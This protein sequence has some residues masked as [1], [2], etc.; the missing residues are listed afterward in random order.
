M[1]ETGESTESQGQ[2]EESSQAARAVPATDEGERALGPEDIDLVIAWVAP[3]GVEIQTYSDYL[4]ETLSRPEFGFDVS[5]IKLID[6]IKERAD[7]LGGRFLHIDSQNY[8]RSTR[9][10]QAA[11]DWL[12]E[13]TDPGILAVV[14]MSDIKAYREDN[15]QSSRRAFIVRSLKHTQE[16]VELRAVYGDA[17]FLIGAHSSYE[18]RLAFLQRKCGGSVDRANKLMEID[19]S[20]GLDHGQQTRDLFELCDAYVRHSAAL[21]S[22]DTKTEID[23]IV[24]LIFGAISV[25]PRADEY[26]MSIAFRSAEQSGDL[27]RQVGSAVFSKGGDLISTGRNDVPKAGGGVYRVRE[28]PD[29]SDAALRYDPGQK[30]RDDLI[31]D[32]VGQVA[33]SDL[34]RKCG[35]DKQRAELTAVVKATRLKHL[36]EF[37]RSVHAEMDALTS[38]ARRGVSTQDATLYVTTFPCHTCARHIIASGIGRVVYLEPYPKSRALELHGD[39]ICCPAL[40]P[41]GLPLL[42][43]E[44]VTSVDSRE[45]VQFEPLVGISPR[46]YSDFFSLKTREGKAIE[47]KAPDGTLIGRI[48]AEMA[49]RQLRF[50]PRNEGLIERELNAI[51]RLSSTA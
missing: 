8:Y 20:E 17:F 2:A 37:G 45:K 24:E 38:C 43:G 1:E 7:L 9:A 16:A 13:V 10:K 15:K 27:A 36:I 19:A 4:T 34:G 25:S 51:R 14:A 22:K 33:A 23:R 12:R 5:Q 18:D 49:L 44:A 26:G 31:E 29:V 21:D 6:H 47:R 11:G 32:I 40:R 42:S 46:R 35:L 41:E 30:Y 39:A 3:I 50:P 48:G 28:D